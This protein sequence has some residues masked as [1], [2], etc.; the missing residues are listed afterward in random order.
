MGLDKQRRAGGAWFVIAVLALLAA[1]AYVVVAALTTS[2]LTNSRD[3][4]ALLFLGIAGVISLVGWW[5][6]RARRS[7]AEEE[8][9]LERE[10]LES[11]ARERET[12]LDELDS[13]RE[14]E[15]EQR[16]TREQLESRLEDREK[17]LNRERYLRRRSEESRQAKGEWS[18][19]LQAEVMRM[20]RELGAL[21]DTANVPMMVLR[22][23]KKLL[24]AEKGLLLSRENE[25]SDGK[26]DLIAT[27]GF[28][29]DSKDSAIARRFADKVIEHDKIIREDEPQEVEGT[30][31]PADEEIEN[32]VA[33][34]I[35]VQDSFSGVIVCA[36]KEGG[37]GEYDEEVLLSLGNQAGAVLKNGR[38]QGELR[39]SYL[40]TVR[41]LGEAIE[42]KDPFLRGH[43][44]EVSGYVSAVADRLGLEPL[45]REQL[46]FAS[47]LH[48]VGKIGISERILLSPRSLPRRS[49]IS[50]SC[51]RVSVTTSCSRYPRW[52]RW[53]TASSTTTSASTA[54]ATPRACAERRS[55]WRPASSAWRTRSAR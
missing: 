28:E 17:N 39:S 5:W 29:N 36:N 43:S 45:R 18:R 48:D 33:I 12:R 4:A 10:R 16:R 55:R 52:T 21:G 11:E 30:S 38:L 24:G 50:S 15:A 6:D 31:T 34:P 32:L 9:R 8:A 42:A 23:S 46:L 25:D 53:P 41:V 14:Q 27:E 19:Q 47:L 37:F 22:L 7:K 40:A 26:L 13:L 1:T 44:E 20:H 35:Y 51:T 2:D 3:D 49:S 54:P